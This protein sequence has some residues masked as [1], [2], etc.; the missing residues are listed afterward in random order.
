MVCRSW[1]W[2][3]VACVLLALSPWRWSDP[4]QRPPGLG[5]QALLDIGR[6]LLSTADRPVAD[7]VRPGPF[8]AA[9]VEPMTLAALNTPIR[10]A[11]SRKLGRVL[12]RL[13]L[14]G[15]ARLFVAERGL[16]PDL[17]E[18]ALATL[19]KLGVTL[20]R[21]SRLTGL[22][23]DGRRVWRLDVR[24]A[25]IPLERADSVVLALPPG[26]LARLLPGLQVPT[27]H[28]P[29]VNLHLTTPYAGRTRFVGLVGG[30]A[31]W[32]LVRP[33]RISLTVSAARGTVDLPAATLARTIWQEAAQASRLM[34]LELP[35]G[36]LPAWR[37]I[38]ERRATISQP[39]GSPLRV[40]PRPFENLALAGDWLS[41]M[42]ATIEIGGRKRPP[43]RAGNGLRRR[44]APAVAPQP[45]GEC[46]NRRR[47]PSPRCARRTIVTGRCRSS[48]GAT[49]SPG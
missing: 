43:C 20:H 25:G 44:P 39:A 33:G 49:C 40:N 8:L 14:P 32:M 30:L 19:R 36:D 47:W 34:S 35:S 29:I 6:L 22:G 18:P 28:E 4:D 15:S 45:T 37:V 24:G 46:L 17:V 42:P 13:A 38:K 9:M 26:E 21:G 23:I 31:Q 12:R 7:M 16:G 3:A 41:A 5:W 10:E 11:S 1:T 48:S 2:R 27:R